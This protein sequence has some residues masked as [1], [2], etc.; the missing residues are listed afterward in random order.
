MTGRNPYLQSKSWST[1]DHYLGVRGWGLI[2]YGTLPASLFALGFLKLETIKLQRTEIWLPILCISAAPVGILFVLVYQ[3][4]SAWYL[5]REGVWSR[6]FIITALILLFSTAISLMAG[7]VTGKYISISWDDWIGLDIQ[8]RWQPYL[9]SFLIAIMSLV[10]SSTLFLT[11]VKDSG[12]LPG[13]PS[14][15]VVG[16]LQALREALRIIHIDSIWQKADGVATDRLAEEIKTSLTRLASLV[17]NLPRNVNH[18][19]LYD[20]LSSDLSQLSEA[21]LEV[22]HLHS[23]WGYY[24]DPDY[25]AT[26]LSK[27]ELDRRAAVLRLKMMCKDG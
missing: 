2:F 22:G 10:G 18:K 17:Q 13:L 23:N 4:L 25:Q 1:F 26:G 12:G 20:L 8:L 9:E 27:A 7:I 6:S 19:S 14:G 21:I 15:G 16:D 3:R 24:F 11:A 5:F